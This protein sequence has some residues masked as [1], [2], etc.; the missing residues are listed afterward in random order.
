MTTSRKP[1]RWLHDE[2]KT[3]PLSVVARHEAGFLLQ[4][5]QEGVKL[6]MPQSRPLP[7]IGKGCHELRVRDRN[8]NWRIV[9][10]VGT[11]EV[12]SW[13]WWQRSPRSYRSR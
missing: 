12:W 8:T 10:H 11:E 5:L 1:I 4:Q 13:P 2:I 9:V 3:P 7:I 6:G